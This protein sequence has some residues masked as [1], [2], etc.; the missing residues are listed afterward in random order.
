MKDYQELL[1]KFPDS[2][3]TRKQII[4]YLE[5]YWLDKRELVDVWLKIKNTIFKGNSTTYPNGL[6]N[7]NFDI[8]IVKGGPVLDRDYFEQL[9]GCMKVTGD[10]YFIIL[11]DNDEDIPLGNLPPSPGLV[12]WPPLRFKFPVGITFDEI[13][14]GTFVSME[15]FD[16]PERDY[17]IFGNSGHWGIYA[18]DDFATPLHVIGFKK[19]YSDVFHRN[20][21]IS[22]E[23]IKDLQ[24]WTASLGMKFPRVD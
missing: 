7:D 18:G 8:M 15:A 10:N 16:L 19:E 11:E 23:D 14:A 5:Q 17:F 2:L 1:A 4:D 21:K 9:Q 22:K 6:L 13:M 3:N 20:I 12:G 24:E